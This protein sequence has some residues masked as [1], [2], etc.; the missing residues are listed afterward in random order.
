MNHTLHALALALPLLAGT[1][2]GHGGMYTG[3]TPSLPP[4]VPGAGPGTPMPAGPP[5]GGP[6][7][8]GPATG[9][10]GATFA[11]K[12]RAAPSYND[13]P[14]WWRLNKQPYLNLRAR[15]GSLGSVTG[16]G[17]DGV[18]AAPEAARSPRPGFDELKGGALAVLRRL[19]NEDDPDIVDSAVLAMARMTP[20]D[21]AALVL[22]DITRTLAHDERTVKQSAIL[23]LGVLGSPDAAPVLLEILGDTGDGRRALGVKQEI[24]EVFR[25]FAAISLGYLSEPAAIDPIRAQADR[26]P[27]SDL[28]LRAG[29]ILALGLYS[30]DQYDIVAHLRAGLKD[31]R[32]PE[33]V[34]AQIPIA[35]ARLGDASRPLVSELLKLAKA[36][37]TRNLV[38]QSCVVALGRL[39]APEDLEVVEALLDIARTESDEP[40]R[41]F[42]LIAL[43]E[44]GARA[45]AA[46]NRNEELVGAITR[47]TLGDVVRPKK[48]S[49]LPWAAT[50]S[51]LVARALPKDDAQRE[52]IA[53]RLFAAWKKTRNP[54]ERAALA[55]SLG[56]IESHAHGDLLL[57]ELKGSKNRDQNGYLAE[58]LGLMRFDDARP[59]LK[60]LLADE[61]DVEYRVQLST[62]LGLMGDVEVSRLLAEEMSEAKTLS[63]ISAIAKAI[64]NVGDRTALSPLLK[65]A[66]DRRRPGL[67]RGFACVAIGLVGEK[68]PL[69]WNTRVNVGA[70][71]LAAFYTQSEIMAIL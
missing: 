4:Y 25:A 52:T 17:R 39:A 15:L 13:W 5:T 71:Y 3:P 44:I 62:G 45:A 42:A 47:V 53:S 9:P 56:L 1:A 41:N 69:P 22:D 31:K 18:T 59:A 29:S 57:R 58:A 6:P 64:G 28:D 2:L 26:A 66:Q 70:N 35:I 8:G 38:R 14:T 51:A 33:V 12:K 43:G 10:G 67:A 24:D 21:Q 11:G 68:T 34:Q 32:M 65:L 61:N 60:E 16:V 63:D 36:R 55:I 40:S 27:D 30:S 49:N 37:K 7:G 48:R 46:P 54:D 50:A 19:L 23:A 20:A